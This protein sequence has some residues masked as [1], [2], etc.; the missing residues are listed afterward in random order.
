MNYLHYDLHL[1]TGE[2]VEVILD[3]Q[4]NVR[5]LDDSN[6]SNYQRGEQHLYYGG[7]A[8]RS[9]VCLSRMWWNILSNPSIS[10]NRLS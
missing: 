9:P 4:A 10:P 8:T 3:K 5:L 6:F 1:Q 7:L 2:A